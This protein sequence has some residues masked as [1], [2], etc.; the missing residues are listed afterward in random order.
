MRRANYAIVRDTHP[1][2]IVIRDIGPW[3][4][5][6]T[7]TNAADLVVAELQAARQL[8]D[9]RKLFYYDSEGEYGEIAY[10]SGTI[11]FLPATEV[12]TINVTERHIE[13]SIR[14]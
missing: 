2:L 11:Q 7:V 3:D 5:Y 4:A 1:D 6:Q 8:R 14:G 12:R 13:R 10:Q 9:G